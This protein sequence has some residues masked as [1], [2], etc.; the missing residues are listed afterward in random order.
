MEQEFNDSV[1]PGE[2]VAVF[3]TSERAVFLFAE[4]KEVD[5]YQEV[6]FSEKA[7]MSAVALVSG[8][9]NNSG[10]KNAVA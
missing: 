9:T 10:K 2:K 6:R 5:E 7:P 1:G 4:G 3:S 8:G